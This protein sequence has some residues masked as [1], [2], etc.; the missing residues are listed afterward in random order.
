[1]IKKKFGLKKR[2]N[3]KK[4]ENRDAQNKI[5]NHKQLKLTYWRDGE[6]K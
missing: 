4:V 3:Y 5:L 2:K 6:T 1:M